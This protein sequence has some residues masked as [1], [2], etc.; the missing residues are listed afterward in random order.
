MSKYFDF[1]EEELE[2]HNSI[3][4]YSDHKVEEYSLAQD[5]S[6]IKG[7]ETAADIII[8]KMSVDKEVGPEYD[9]LVY[10]LLNIYVCIIEF[11][12]KLVLK[13]LLNHLNNGCEYLERPKSNK[14]I[15]LINNNH[16]LKELFK[17][18]KDILNNKKHPHSNLDFKFIAEVI[19][20]FK[21]NAA[22]AISTQYHYTN[23]KYIY[24]FYQE[25]KNIK[26]FKLHEDIKKIIYMALDYPN[27]EDF[28]LCEL[29]FLTPWGLTKL[30]EIQQLSIESAKLFKNVLPRKKSQDPPA[31]N[32]TISAF[33]K[34]LKPTAEEV[35]FYDNIKHLPIKQKKAL[36]TCLYL[37]Y[38]PLSQINVE[39]ISDKEIDDKIYEYKHL[40]QR[41][42]D[43][44]KQYISEISQ[45]QL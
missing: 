44:L 8:Q 5:Y 18:L 16:D 14:L 28:K 37:S 21:N 7:F 32:L 36:L 11:S 25:L 6:L 9:N 42:I 29:Q 27:N 12:L 33:I 19:K 3:A 43:N 4:S 34:D 15:R 35:K 13:N 30:K 17:N 45:Y 26:I 31:M 23:M 10:P 1:D 41:G 22:S 40:Y 39:T 38:Q 20:S 2:E 24:P